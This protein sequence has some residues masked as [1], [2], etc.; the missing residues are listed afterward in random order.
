[1]TKH[2]EQ[3]EAFLRFLKLVSAIRGLPRLDALEERVLNGLAATWATG[4]SITVLLAMAL[5]PDTSPTTV[6][7]R[8][9]SPRKLGLIDLFEDHEDTRIKYMV[10]TE[11]D[12]AYFAK[13]SQ[14]TDRATTGSGLLLYV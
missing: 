8:L 3:S 7:R 14:C 12:K 2:D 4:A 6:H 9:K 13:V 1:M 5:S 11:S 10:A